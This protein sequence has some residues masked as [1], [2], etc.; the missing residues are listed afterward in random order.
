MLGSLADT[1]GHGAHWLGAIRGGLGNPLKTLETAGP[2]GAVVRAA[3]AAGLAARGMAATAGTAAAGRPSITILRFD[4]NQVARKEA[5]IDLD[6]RFAFPETGAGLRRRRIVADRGAGSVI[7]FDAGICAG[8]EDLRALANAVLQ[9]AVDRML[10]D[11]A[12]ATALAA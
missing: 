4:C 11:P 2:V 8:V 10:D 5:H 3:I 1:R 6:V 7:T 12:L 9:E